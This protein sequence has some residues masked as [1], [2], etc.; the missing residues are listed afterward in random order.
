M[1]RKLQLIAAVLF[2]GL[3]AANATSKFTYNWSHVVDGPTKAGDNVIALKKSLDADGNYL[4][5]TAWGSHTTDG[6][7]LS[8]DGQTLD[9]PDGK[10]IITGSPYTGTSMNT[11]LLL[12]KLN[13]GSGSPVW[14]VFTCHGDVDAGSSSMAATNDGGA[15]MFVKIRRTLNL[16]ACDTLVSLVD[17][18]GDTLSIKGNDPDVKTHVYEG[19]ILRV[20]TDGKF[21]W[22]KGVSLPATL[23]DGT[24]ATNA[25]YFYSACTDGDGNLYVCGNYRNAMTLACADGTAITLTPQNIVGWDGDSQGTVGD[26]FLIKLDA[27]GN[28]VDNLTTSGAAKSVFFDN[29]AYS[30]GKIYIQGHLTGDGSTTLTLGDKAFTPGMFADELLASV[31]TDLS[32]NYAKVF[33]ATASTDKKHTTQ[34]KA[35]QMIDGSVYLFGLVKGG[36]AD[37]TNAEPFVN[38]AATSLEGYLIRCNASDGSFSAAGSYGSGITGYYGAIPC[39]DSLLVYGYNMS[40]GAVIDQFD[41]ATLAKGK[42]EAVLVKCGIV[43]LCAPPVIDGNMFVSMNR[44]GNGK[45]V[46]TASFYATDETISGII[47][48]CSIIS[49]YKIKDYQPTTGIT[50]AVASPRSVNYDVYSVSGVLIKKATNMNSALQD[51]AKG[52]YVIG[53]KKC[54]VS[55]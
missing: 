45:T 41:K 8:V 52:I 7:N 24:K 17:A 2:L 19:I 37:G 55:E 39:R 30:D 53:N 22:S 26:A 48:W 32:V 33:T 46:G 38:S 28:Y 9:A 18:H 13:P 49:S 54:V 6:R 34:N 23:P 31:N 14:S 11:N 40:K 15:V 4:A 12:Q 29:V 44:G 1:K 10:G 3:N 47:N 21:L 43:A 50:D 20:N 51:L 36:F 25:F 42:F 5:M 27:D 16:D 35:I